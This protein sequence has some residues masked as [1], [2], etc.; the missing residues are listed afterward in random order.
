[1]HIFMKTARGIKI[2]FD[3]FE[4]DRMEKTLNEKWSKANI[5]LDLD[6]LFIEDSPEIPD[7]IKI[8]PTPGHTFFHYS[9]LIDANEIKNSCHRRC[10][11]HEN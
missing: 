2:S 6:V 4:A 8:I 5:G 3:Q 10:A 7:L 1:M 9:F 11:Q